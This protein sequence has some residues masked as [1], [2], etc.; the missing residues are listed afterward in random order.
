MSTARLTMGRERCCCNSTYLPH[1]TPWTRQHFCDVSD[2]P[3]EYPAQ[4]STGSARTWCAIPSQS[5]SVRCS[6]QSST[7]STVSHKARCL[8]LCCSPCTC[9]RSRTSSARS[10]SATHSTRTTLNCSLLSTTSNQ[11]RRYL[12]ASVQCNTGWI[13]TVWL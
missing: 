8:D 7:V 9:P 4:H 13:L 2:P 5:E 3:S 10:V 6:R 11:H 1:S 12:N